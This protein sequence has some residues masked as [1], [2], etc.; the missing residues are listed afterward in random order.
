MTVG[1]NTQRAIVELAQG[2]VSRFRPSL[3]AARTSDPVAE[4]HDVLA[5]LAQAGDLDAH[6]EVVCPNDE[7]HRTAA[8]YPSV[9]DVPVGDELTCPS[10][11]TFVVALRTVWAYY[12][13]SRNMLLRLNRVR[14]SG[15]ETENASEHQGGEDDGEPSPVPPPAGRPRAGDELEA[16]WARDLAT[17]GFRP[18]GNITLQYIERVEA[19]GFVEQHSP[20]DGSGESRPTI[21]HRSPAERRSLL[22]RTGGFFAGPFFKHPV[23]APLTVIVVAAVGGFIYHA[24]TRASGPQAPSGSGGYVEIEAVKAGAPTF[25]RYH[26]ASGPGRRVKYLEAVRVSCKVR[27]ATIK[28]VLPGGYWYRLQSAPWNNLYYAAANTFLNGDPVDG[29]YSHPTDLDVR[30]C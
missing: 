10:G 9:E 16:G 29:P 11:H 5:Q 23:I 22:R 15:D 8:F 20:S 19:G 6:F 2:G 26:N 3:V 21:D 25:L 28:S 24:A 12:T 13:P 17:G 18:A 30:D 4:V 27:D 1:E 14:A 7:C